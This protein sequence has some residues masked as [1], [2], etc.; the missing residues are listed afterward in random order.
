MS[1]TRRSEPPFEEN[2]V[3]VHTGMPSYKWVQWDIRSFPSYLREA[4]G[5]NLLCILHSSTG[6]LVT[7]GGMEDGPVKWSNIPW[8]LHNH[9]E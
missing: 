4:D 2:P 8:L 9:T 3:S 7:G 6:D 5:I 1:K